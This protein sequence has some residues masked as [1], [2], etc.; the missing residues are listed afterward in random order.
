MSGSLEVPERTLAQKPPDKDIKNCEIC[1]CVFVKVVSR[2]GNSAL[3][4]SWVRKVWVNESDGEAGGQVAELSKSLWVTVT[5][6]DRLSPPC[7]TVIHR[8]GTGHN[9]SRLLG[10]RDRHLALLRRKAGRE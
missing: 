5:T 1:L 4:P 10:S 8:D 6:V 9:L 3:S 2:V 7:E